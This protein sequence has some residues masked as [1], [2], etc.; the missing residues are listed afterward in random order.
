M[1]V[2]DSGA[3]RFCEMLGEGDSVL[4]ECA[5][6]HDRTGKLVFRV[7]K[8]HALRVPGDFKV[9]HTQPDVLM[10]TERLNKE[11]WKIGYR[12]EDRL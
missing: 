6:K 2:W 8:F 3:A 12:H 4:V 5:V 11:D 10:S 9:L 7:S 1:E